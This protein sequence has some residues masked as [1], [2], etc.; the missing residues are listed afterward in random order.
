MDWTKGR[1]GFDP[2]QRRKDFLSILCVQT[3]LGPIQP[4]VQW[5][6]GVP[7]SGLNRGRGVTLTTHPH[8]VQRTSMSK[9]YITS[10]DLSVF[11]ACS[12]TA[13]VFAS[14]SKRNIVYLQVWQRTIWARQIGRADL[15]LT[16]RVFS[17]RQSPAALRIK[18]RII[19]CEKESRFGVNMS[20]IINIHGHLWK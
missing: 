16:Y 14:L 5:V 2:W 10:S 4:P 12:G 3:A 11:M 7:S 19:C 20:G 8:L 15:P 1:S 9:S 17:V 13:L 18:R 6:P